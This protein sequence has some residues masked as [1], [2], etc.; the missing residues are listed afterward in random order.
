MFLNIIQFY[1]V[2]VNKKLNICTR[3]MKN[4]A[5]V[6]AAVFWTLNL[7]DVYLDFFAKLGGLHDTVDNS[8]IYDD[9]A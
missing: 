4:T 8:L 6:S 5:A 9:L 2:F 7:G 3:K 1:Y